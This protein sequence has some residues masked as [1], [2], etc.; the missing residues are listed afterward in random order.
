[1][2]VA[3]LQREIADW[4][5]ELN[6]D[7][8]P[9]SILAKLLEEVAELLASD[10]KDPLELADVAILLLD[11][12]YLAEVDMAQAVTAKMELNRL[13]SWQIKPDGRMQHVS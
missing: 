9:I 13:R 5:N 7:R 2:R 3:E 1:M 11:L 12:F 8:K 6:P 10:M 4:A